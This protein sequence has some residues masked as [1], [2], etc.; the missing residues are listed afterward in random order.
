MATVRRKE[1]LAEQ[2]L[3]EV[4]IIVQTEMDDP[5]LQ[6]LTVTHVEMS[7]DLHHARVFVSVME[8]EGRKETLAALHH[9]RG[10]IRSLLASRL[11]MRRVPSLHF[12]LDESLENSLRVW[13]LLDLTKAAKPRD[14][15]EF[16]EEDNEHDE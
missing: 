4:A 6:S 15:I 14:D 10:Y 16:E 5:R 12:Y 8:E 2:I 1:R 3:E 7:D 9:A 11:T 13:E